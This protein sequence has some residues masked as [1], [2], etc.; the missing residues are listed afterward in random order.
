MYFEKPGQRVFDIKI[1][2]SIVI[3]DMDVFE[4][5]GAK[6]AAHEEYLEFE[7]KDAAVYVNGAKTKNG[8]K[9]GNLQLTFSKGKADNPIIQAII[10]YQGPV[11]GKKVLK[12]RNNEG[13]LLEPE[14]E[15]GIAQLNVEGQEGEREGKGDDSND[16]EEGEDCNQK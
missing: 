15:L 11:A 7:V 14:E 5:T 4:R 2:D 16:Q 6:Y 8:L 10:V 3:Q 12:H 13:R 1:G 9:G